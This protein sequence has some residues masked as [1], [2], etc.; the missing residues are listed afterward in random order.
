MADA[1]LFHERHTAEDIGD[2]LVQFF[3]LTQR[4]LGDGTTCATERLFGLREQVIDLN[5][6]VGTELLGRT[7]VFNEFWRPYHIERQLFVPLTERTR[8]VGYLC[9][10]RAMSEPPFRASEVQRASWLRRQAVLAIQRVRKSGSEWNS[11]L[12]EALRAL[13]LPCA[14]FD[15]TGRLLWLS[16]AA[17]RML[18]LRLVD[19]SVTRLMKATRGFTSWRGAVERAFAAGHGTIQEGDLLLQRL[20]NAPRDMMLVTHTGSERLPERRVDRLQSCWCLT[21]R[22]TEVLLELAHGL[23]NKDIGLKLRCSFRTVEVHVASILVKSSCAS[24]TELLA[25]VWVSD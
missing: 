2:A 21:P 25:R 19:P 17:E 23:S 22:E 15:G 24:R 13:P 1:T 16:S 3:P 11:G 4:E 9:L 10:G 8:P 7:T 18:G 14:L 20:T 5:A 12:V 6:L